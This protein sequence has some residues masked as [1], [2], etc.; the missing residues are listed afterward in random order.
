MRHTGRGKHV[1]VI[2][3]GFAGL[4]AAYELCNH[5][6]KV[7]VLEKDEHIGGLASSFETNGCRL[8]K[9]YHHF[10]NHDQYV[11]QLVKELGC[12]DE[13]VRRPTNTG[14]YCDRRIIKLSTPFDLLR[15]E[16]LGL[17][18]RIRLGLLVMWV[19]KVKDWR[20]LDSITAQ[21]WLTKLC[22]PNVYSVLWEPLLRGKFGAYASQVSAAWFWSKLALRGASRNKK[23]AEMLVYYRGGFSS[24]ADKIAENITKTGGVI[25]TAAEATGLVVENHRI[26]AVRTPDGTIDADAVIAT[27]ALPVIAQLV[28][29]YVDDQYVA[30]LGKIK[31][32]ANICLVLELSHGLS[33]IYWLN[34]ND[35]EFPFVGVIEHTNFQPVESSG[36]KHIVYLSKYLSQPDQMYKMTKEHLFEFAL[37]HIKR[38]FPKFDDSWVLGYH[39]WKSPYAQTVTECNYS[40]LIPAKRTP[41]SGFY[42]ATMAQ[43]YPEDR[44]INYAIREGRN[45]ATLAAKTFE[46]KARND[47]DE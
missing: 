38:M 4:A 5:N 37:P 23:G 25:K 26:K 46:N 39:V 44:G 2:G 1:V 36:G 28:E 8:E 41:V 14:I 27:P 11:V 45:I 6:I 31:Y 12:L 3:A 13:L 16:P 35:A 10:F 17:L 47:N 7:T 42:I 15:F 34:V 18:D 30:G 33:G 20:P 19:P 9:F 22:G 32:L 21:Q 29:P 40:T 43:I 24:L